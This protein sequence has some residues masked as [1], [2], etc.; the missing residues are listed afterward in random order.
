MNKKIFFLDLFAFEPKQ[1]SKHSRRI[2]IDRF[3]VC[4]KEYWYF[5][6]VDLYIELLVLLNCK[7]IGECKT[8][9]SLLKWI[10]NILIN[11]WDTIKFIEL[12]NA[13]FLAQH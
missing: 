10:V 11:K 4:E 5:D 9:T 3:G 6:C 1:I 12:N 7:I 8:C 13:L 2:N